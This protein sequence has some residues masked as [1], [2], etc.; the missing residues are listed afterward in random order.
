M[1][2]RSFK[3]ALD[4][5]PPKIVEVTQETTIK[6]TGGEA[7]GQ[8]VVSWRTDEPATS[9]VEYADGSNAS[10]FNFRTAEDT[11]LTT[12]H[13][14]IVSDLPTSRV[15]SLRPASK[16]KSGNV[17]Y[18]DAQPAIIGRAS[19]NVLTVVLNALRKV[20]GF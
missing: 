2:F 13:I 6:G 20:F 4:T 3:T 12:E 17:A 18:G 11:N 19:E 5:R 14:V 8:V 7:R 9:Y 1:L 10:V 16:D 15:Y